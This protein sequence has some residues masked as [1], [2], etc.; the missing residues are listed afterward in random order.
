MFKA[1]KPE[2]RLLSDKFID[3]IIDEA[4]KVLENIGVYIENEEAVNMLFENNV[5]YDKKKNRFYFDAD[6]VNKCLKSVPEEV[7]LYNRDGSE[8]IVLGDNNVCFDPGSAA[9]DILDFE[10][11]VIRKPVTDDYKKYVLLVDQLENIKAQST[12]FICSDVP[13]Y[14]SD[15]YR[16]YLSLIL[17]N[18]PVVTGTFYKQ[19]FD[20]MKDMLVAVRGSAKE[21]KEKPLAIFDACPSPPLKWSDLTSQSLLDCAKYGIPSEFVSMPLLGAT[22]PATLSGALVQHTAENLSGTVLTQLAKPGT[23]IIYGGSPAIFDM[24]YGTTPM[25]AIETMMVDSAYNQIGKKLGIPTHAYMGLSDSKYLDYQSGLESGIGLILAALSG[26]NMVSGAGMLNFESCQSL[27]KLVMDN[28]ICG[29]AYRL[30][31]GIS[32]KEETMAFYT[33]RDCLE[34]EEFITHESTLKHFRE[35]TFFVNRAIDR[36]SGF[37]AKD[38]ADNNA[39]K[40]ANE[41]VKELLSK[42]P[43]NILKD[44]TLKKL[45]EIIKEEGKRNNFKDFPELD[46]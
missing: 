36:A 24:K 12:A 15:S 16:L 27:E 19:S 31:K 45:K 11:N 30:L 43:K 14:M 33:L 10:K 20:T 26:V 21:L 5:K 2:I 39:F 32:Q 22:A 38:A 41:I 46:V 17:S 6:L 37:N 44:N 8:F 18:K 7:K 40:R 29:M 25:G 23:P 28:Q 3:R 9:L 35:E 42:T 34:D 13:K 1:K 4:I